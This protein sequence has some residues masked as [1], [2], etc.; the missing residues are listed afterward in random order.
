MSPLL[1]PA[2][3]FCFLLLKSL[4]AIRRP[5]LGALLASRCRVT[6]HGRLPPPLCEDVGLI[7]ASRKKTRTE[8]HELRDLVR[9][10]A[11]RSE[12]RRVGK[13]CVMT[14]IS[15]WWPHH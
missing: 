13:A 9:V 5:G 1:G 12:E 8:S 11:H 2:R 4:I 10:I 3:G 15:R 6:Q 7:V 14:S